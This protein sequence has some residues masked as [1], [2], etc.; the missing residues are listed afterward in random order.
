MQDCLPL[1]ERKEKYGV[2]FQ[3]QLLEA[4]ERD[5][6]HFE[7]Y[8]SHLFNVLKPLSFDSEV[9]YKLDRFI[10]RGW[11]FEEVDQWLEDPDASRIFWISGGPGVGRLPYPPT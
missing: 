6:L 2:T 10:G 5:M 3:R 4:L 1:E 8:H 11:V 7:G 9:R